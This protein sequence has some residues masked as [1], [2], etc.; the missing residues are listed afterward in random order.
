M[1]TLIYNLQKAKEFFFFLKRELKA[2][3]ILEVLQVL[4]TK[5]F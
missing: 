2:E 5:R 4:L 1:P 3:N